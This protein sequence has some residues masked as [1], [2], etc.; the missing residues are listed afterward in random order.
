MTIETGRCGDGLT[1]T[2]DPDEARPSGGGAS[3][4]SPTCPIRGIL[5]IIPTKTS[6]MPMKTN[7]SPRRGSRAWNPIQYKEEL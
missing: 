4:P 2:F 6:G 7:T 5:P 1:W 3:A